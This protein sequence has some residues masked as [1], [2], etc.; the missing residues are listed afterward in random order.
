MLI[1][2]FLFWFCSPKTFWSE[3]SKHFFKNT[4]MGLF[5][6]LPLLVLILKVA[7]PTC[8]HKLS[9]TGAQWCPQEGAAS[10]TIVFIIFHPH[11]ASFTSSRIFSKNRFNFKIMCNLLWG[12]YLSMCLP[13]SDL[14]NAWIGA[15]ALCWVGIRF[16][17]SLACC[18]LR[19]QAFN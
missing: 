6:R 4:K 5:R 16:N 1:K 10:A 8:R 2:T 19:P 18:R 9:W 3:K 15:S 13:C 14:R 17:S 7:S 12:K 11:P